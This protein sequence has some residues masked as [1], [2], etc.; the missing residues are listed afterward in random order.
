MT[1]A[2]HLCLFNC[3][4]LSAARLVIACLT[5]HAVKNSY[6]HFVRRLSSQ[7]E[8]GEIIV[9]LRRVVSALLLKF[10]STSGIGPRGL[11]PKR[12][13]NSSVTSNVL[14]QVPVALFHAHRFSAHP[15]NLEAVS[16]S[17]PRANSGNS[18]HLLIPSNVLVQEVV[19]PI[20]APLVGAAL[21]Q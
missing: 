20:E 4:V 5:Y 11:W 15:S 10:S 19:P 13:A 12:F 21:R 18:A 3:C 16:G 17:V 9:L 14:P 6:V 1:I 7:G 8:S 2:P